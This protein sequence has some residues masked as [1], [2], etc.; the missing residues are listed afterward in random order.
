MWQDSKIQY[1]IKIL[2]ELNLYNKT[3]FI[4][5]STWFCNHIIVF[6]QI[7]KLSM[8]TGNNILYNITLLS[9]YSNIFAIILPCLVKMQDNNKIKANYI[10]L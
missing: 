7:K 2:I 1:D 8:C 4:L 10:S 9:I 6:S 5:L 3:W